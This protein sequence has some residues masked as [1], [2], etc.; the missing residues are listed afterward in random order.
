ME[1]PIQLQQ[2]EKNRFLTAI[3]L[4]EDTHI[5]ETEQLEELKRDLPLFLRVGEIYIEEDRLKIA[6]ETDPAFVPLSSKQSSPTEEKKASLAHLFQLRRLEGSPYIPY[7]DPD[8]LFVH[9]EHGLKIGHRGLREVLPPSNDEEGELFKAF[10]ACLLSMFSSY[11]FHHI[12]RKGSSHLTWDESRLAQRMAQAKRLDELEELISP[13]PNSKDDPKRSSKI[14]PFILAGSMLVLGLGIGFSGGTSA[15]QDDSKSLEYREEVEELKGQLASQQARAAAYQA[16]LQNDHEKAIRLLEGLQ[17]VNGETEALLDGTIKSLREANTLKDSLKEAVVENLVSLQTQE[18][19]Q[20]ILQIESKSPRV[21]ME[22]AWINDD[23]EKV[24]EL[25]KK[26]NGTRSTWL[27]ANSYFQL[28]EYD[29]AVSLA[30]EVNET[31]FAIRVLK[32]KKD[33]VES[34]EGL[35]EE[36]KEE[37]LS[38]INQQIE[39]LQS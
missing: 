16:S 30:K 2:D 18:A 11:S 13:P 24:L 7:M 23:Y 6:Y 9:P 8:N 27:A 22:K 19:N 12:L 21:M 1:E 25:H 5:V 35:S 17:N 34:D 28:S 20:V 14:N 4:K 39:N 29:Q 32:A 37:Q 36:E 10:Q 26:V 31:D 38:R 33:Q 3:V 15:D